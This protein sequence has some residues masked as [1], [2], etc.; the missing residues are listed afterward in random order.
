MGFTC[1]IGLQAR[2][3]KTRRNLHGWPRNMPGVGESCPC[4]PHP[5]H[6]DDDDDGLAMNCS[7]TGVGTARNDELEDTATD[8]P[9]RSAAVGLVQVG[10]A[11]SL[12]SSV[13][14]VAPRFLKGALVLRIPKEASWCGAK[15]KGCVSVIRRLKSVGAHDW[16][17]IGPVQNL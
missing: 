6:D 14:E 15:V 5:F 4:A 10:R 3:G 12:L 13:A 2:T 17:C 7:H 11:M 8:R 1:L 9:Q 16:Q